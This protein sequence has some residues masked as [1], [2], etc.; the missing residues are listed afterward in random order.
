MAEEA[1]PV[2]DAT[3][4]FRSLV[5]EVAGARTE[6]LQSDSPTY[7]TPEQV[8]TVRAQSAGIPEIEYRDKMAMEGYDVDEAIEKVGKEAGFFDRTQSAA[9]YL[10]FAERNRETVKDLYKK[11]KG[12]EVVQKAQERVMVGL[13]EKAAKIIIPNGLLK[14]DTNISATWEK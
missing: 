2:F 10:D 1:T 8:V 13:M 12:P 4:E 3:A 9:E 6:I 14:A 7:D 11:A 5:G